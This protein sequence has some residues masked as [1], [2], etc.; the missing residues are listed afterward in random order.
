MSS[1]NKLKHEHGK[2]AW[3]GCSHPG[4]YF[5]LREGVGQRLCARHEMVFAYSRGL[6]KAL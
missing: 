6:V 4:F 3:D 2:C 5:V 1:K